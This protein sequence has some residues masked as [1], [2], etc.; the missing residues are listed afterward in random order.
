MKIKII[1]IY[2]VEAD[3]PC[4]ILELE[5][6]NTSEDFDIGSITQE[7]PD[8]PIDNW[9]VPYDEHYLDQNGEILITPEYPEG[10][11]TDNV[12]RVAFY[13]HYLDFN[14]PLNTPV[15]DIDLIKETNKPER[16]NFMVYEPPY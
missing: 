6:Q 10:M 3:E 11:P 9:Q 4:H 16:L 5:I 1:G 7:I 15:G 2:K 14:K 13:F 12:L 8:E